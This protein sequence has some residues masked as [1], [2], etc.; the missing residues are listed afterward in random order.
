MNENICKY[1][2]SSD[3]V[4][5][6]T[7]EGIQRYWC[8][9]CR[10]KF[11]PDSLPKMKTNKAIIS[12]AL[13]C[14][15][16][17]M[18]L[19]AIQTHLNQQHGTYFT[20]GGIYNWITRFGKEAV[21]MASKFKPE[22]GDEWIADETMI[23]V[24]N[25]KVWF[26]DI[27]DTETR[28]LLASRISEART[29]ADA[30]AL[31]RKAAKVAGKNPKVILTDGLHAYWDGIEQA[32]G[33]DSEHII[34]KPITTENSTSMIERFHETLKQRLHVMKNFG[35]IFTANDM[36]DAWLVH[37]NFFKEHEALDN[38]PPAQSMPNVPFKDWNDVVNIVGAKL[39]DNPEPNRKVWYRPPSRPKTIVLN[40]KRTIARKRKSARKTESKIYP[41]V[42]IAK[43]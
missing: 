28:Y 21:E 41:S 8:K 34:S 25:K 31:M 33:S 10:R 6:G 42:S 22:V 37:Y 16:G 39:A 9:D 3:V 4:K 13:S 5:F 15:F 18:T 36:T 43:L 35:D 19:D 12:E 30:E 32:F 38:I 7:F 2:Q 24:G 20:E 17:G 26:W 14:Y 29:T 11:V 40:K 23:N 27:I 1:C